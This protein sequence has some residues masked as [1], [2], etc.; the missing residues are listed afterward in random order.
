MSRRWHR[1]VMPEIS[2]IYVYQDLSGQICVSAIFLGPSPQ[3]NSVRIFFC[4][5]HFPP[6]LSPPYLFFLQLHHHDHHRSLSYA[7][8]RMLGSIRDTRH[9]SISLHYTFVKSTPRCLALPVLCST[10][11]MLCPADTIERQFFNTRGEK[12]R[13]KL[14][15][16]SCLLAQA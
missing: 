16:R 5:S 12:N 14:K 8:A 4:F 13:R 11:L 10:C 6:F 9:R 15:P 7:P 1:L 3:E 2:Y